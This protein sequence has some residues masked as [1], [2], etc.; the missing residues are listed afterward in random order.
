MEKIKSWENL[1]NELV[2]D[3][4]S[5]GIISNDILNWISEFIDYN[6]D[7]IIAAFVVKYG[8]TNAENFEEIFNSFEIAVINKIEN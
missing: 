8:R 3:I 7:E 6:G 4:K 2:D 1:V 5:D